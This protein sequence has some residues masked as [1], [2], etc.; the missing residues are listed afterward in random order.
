MPDLI[1]YGRSAMAADFSYSVREEAGI[2]LGFLDTLGLRQVDLGG[3][4][5]GGWIVEL[6][7]AEHP[8]RVNRLILFDAAGLDIKPDWNT[9]LFTPATPAQLDQ[10][11]ALLTP[12]PQPIPGFI[13]RDILRIVRQRG[14]VVRRATAAMLTGQDVTDSLLP[15]LQMPVLIAWGAQDRIFPTAQA[16]IMH[17]LVPQSELDVFQSCGH[18]SP[19]QCAPQI[20]PKVVGFLRQ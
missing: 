7:A 16:E 1:G 17:R 3:L 15:K 12:N 14:W 20:G 9:A 5:M 8:E 10:L 4:S 18:L 19:V 13:A 2:V 6:V 11:N